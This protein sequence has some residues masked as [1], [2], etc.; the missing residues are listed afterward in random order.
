MPAAAYAAAALEAGRKPAEA[1]GRVDYAGARALVL[2]AIGG[3]G[4]ASMAEPVVSPFAVQALFAHA[5][6]EASEPV[7]PYSVG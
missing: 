7:G 2:S 5:I 6:A 1:S 4:A 3:F